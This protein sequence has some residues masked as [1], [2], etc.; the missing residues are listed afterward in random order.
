[1]IGFLATLGAFLYLFCSD[2]DKQQQIASLV[3]AKKLGC[4]NLKRNGLTF[5]IYGIR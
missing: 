4:E 2:N 3:L 1:M 5:S